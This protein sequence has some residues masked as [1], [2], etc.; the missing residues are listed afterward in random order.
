MLNKAILIGRLTRDPELKTTTSGVS[1]VSFTLAI[2]RGYVK[3]GEERQTDFINCVAW[4]GTADF[5]SKY[6]TKGMMMIV[7]G[8]MQSRSWE[9]TSGNK[10]YAMDVV[11]ENVQ[12]G[13]S[14]KA[15]DGAAG[16]ND[17][18]V[19]TGFTVAEDDDTLPF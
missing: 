19:P 10:R 11:A 14:K 6:F 15:R 9:D 5:I 8:R 16:K 18:D 1:V 2:D 4:R 12:F 17:F 7:E 13:D 3:A